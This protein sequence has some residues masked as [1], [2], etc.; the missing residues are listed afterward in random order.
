M[1]RTLPSSCVWLR[2]QKQEKKK[3][4]RKWFG[5]HS[6]YCTTA[7]DFTYDGERTR[8]CSTKEQ[9]QKEKRGL[10][11]RLWMQRCSVIG[12]WLIFYFFLLEQPWLKGHEIL[13][14]F[15]LRKKE[16]V[17]I[18]CSDFHVHKLLES[19]FKITW[20]LPS[21]VFHTKKKIIFVNFEII[22]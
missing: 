12:P 2:N 19:Q 22:I 13:S 9:N 21:I 7:P 3:K 18:S 16:D 10:L 5:F 11:L 4:K 6:D 15:S 8:Q 17:S 20:L 14:S 1:D